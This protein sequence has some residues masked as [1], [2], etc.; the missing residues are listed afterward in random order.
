MSP[1]ALDRILGYY[2][3][4]TYSIR[5]GELP[6][7]ITRRLPKYPTVPAA[8]IGRLAVDLNG[9]R[10]GLGEHLL[11]DALQRTLRLVKEIGVYAVVVDAKTAAAA[12][13]YARYGFQPFPSE[14]LR[15]FMPVATVKQ[16][17]SE[18]R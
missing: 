7:E 16:A 9:Q 12:L 14:P 3:L 10:Q 13:F 5:P 2:T 17:F 18:G 6:A 15:L 8:L 11:T 1:A 4:S